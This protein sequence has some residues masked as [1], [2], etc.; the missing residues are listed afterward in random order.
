[1]LDVDYTAA[2]DKVPYFIKQM[3]LR[4]LGVVQTSDYGACGLALS[5]GVLRSSGKVVGCTYPP[6]RA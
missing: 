1:M 2:F 6:V 3:S 5:Q 4:R